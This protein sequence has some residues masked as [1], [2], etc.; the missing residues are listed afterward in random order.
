ML[1]QLAK[2]GTRG[3]GCWRA[4]QLMSSRS[5]RSEVLAQHCSWR[6]WLAADW[7]DL[8]NLAEV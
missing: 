8:A 7:L 2:L 1:A 4:A 6:E 5:P 3:I